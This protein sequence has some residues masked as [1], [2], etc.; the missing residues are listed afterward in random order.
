MR[1]IALTVTSI[2]C[3]F[4]LSLT[5][6]SSPTVRAAPA[7]QLSGNVDDSGLHRGDYVQ[8]LTLLQEQY[9]KNPH[10]TRLRW[11]IAQKE[12]ALG[13]LYQ[14]ELNLTPLLQDTTYGIDA[15]YL[16][17]KIYYVQGN[18]V[19]AEKMFTALLKK[20]PRHLMSKFGLLYVY[21]QTNNYAKV[22]TLS[23]T[24]DELSQHETEKAIWALMRSFGDKK[25]Y[26][27][28]WKSDKAVIPFVSMNH[29]PVVSLKVNGRQINALI[30][31]G[32]D[33]FTLDAKLANSLGIKP[34]GSVTGVYAGAKTAHTDFGRLD[35]LEMGDVKLRSVPVNISAF[36]GW[37]A[38]DERTGEVR[39]IDAIVSTGLFQQFL[40]TMD[41]LDRKL[42][43]YPKNGEGKNKLAND[44][45]HSSQV[46]EVP[47]ILD[48][49]HFMI[50]KGT[51]NGKPDMTF[52]LDSGLDHDEAAI[53]LQKEAMDYAGVNLKNARTMLVGENEGGLGGGGFS[54][55]MFTLDSVELGGLRQTAVPGV[56][57]ILP[58]ELYQTESGMLL[59]G[60]ISHQF[61]RHYKWAIDFDRMKMVFFR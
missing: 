19:A 31:T 9:T 58:P 45:T 36:P 53:L 22:K 10:N 52:F 42:V 16:M 51:I 44:L 48:A 40:T 57:G 54:V 56:Y 30:D 11:E 43:F 8:Q 33:L 2:Y 23:L 55:S 12:F 15:M 4:M 49:F 59:D 39:Q 5:L 46:T 25:P 37:T 38:V 61:L 13:N 60:F 32:A 6:L 21:Y 18:Y 26:Q 34:V 27:V 1:I 47:F 28:K 3:S 20:D 7:T 24:A 41:Y 14:A 29:L 17:A 50:A 35:S